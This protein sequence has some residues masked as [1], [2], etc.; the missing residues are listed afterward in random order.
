[1]IYAIVPY[2]SSGTYDEEHH[3]EE[4]HHE[5][6]PELNEDFFNKVFPGKKLKTKMHFRAKVKEAIERSLIKES[7]RFFMNTVI[8]KLVNETG[9]ELPDEFIMKMIREND[10]HKL[11]EE[12]IKNQ[13][14]NFAK[15]IRWQLI[16]SRIIRDNNLQ[17]EENEMRNV[18][19]S[20]FTGHLATA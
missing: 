8:E 10:E 13:Y 2:Q 17:V 7:E 18:V 5:E 12:E 11:S 20:Y 16:E 19:K 3:D 14:D 1:M 15:S 6:L 4:H 9:M